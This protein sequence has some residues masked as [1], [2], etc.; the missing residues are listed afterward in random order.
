MNVDLFASTETDFRKQIVNL[1]TLE[2]VEKGD[3]L[4]KQETPA[5]CLYVI[6]EGKLELT[7][8]FQE[9]L[10][11]TLGPY[12]RGEMIGWSALVKPHIYTMGAR[13]VEDSKL[14]CFNGKALLAL[15][16]SDKKNGYVVM[17]KLTEV[18][19]ARLVNSSIQ[20]MSMRA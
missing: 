6:M 20:L 12:Q 11:D 19:G 18:I 2:K 9:H 14:I 13:A 15:M 16:E 10:I 7:I 5:K 1:G 4:F 3:I 8:T 17:K